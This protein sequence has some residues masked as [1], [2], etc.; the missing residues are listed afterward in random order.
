MSHPCLVNGRTGKTF[1]DSSVARGDYR[2]L[3]KDLESM[4]FIEELRLS[5]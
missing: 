1:L 5:C 3:V 4:K 2:F